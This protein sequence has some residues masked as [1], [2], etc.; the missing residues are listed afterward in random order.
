MATSNIVVKPTSITPKRYTAWH[1]SDTNIDYVS[2]TPTATKIK[3]A[4]R[5]AQWGDIATTVKL[6]E[7]MEAKDA[8]LQGVA[9]TRRM[10]ITALAWEILPNEAATDTKLADEAAVFV[11]ERLRAIPSFRTTL[12]HLQT[13]IGPNIAVAELV[14]QNMEL[15]EFV[16]VPTN[17]LRGNLLNSPIDVSVSTPENVIGVPTDEYGKWIVYSPTLRGGY[18]FKVTITSAQSWLY[19]IK[20][21]VTADWAAFSEVFGMPMRWGTVTEDADVEDIRDKVEDLLRNM[22]ADTHALL[23]AGVDIKA[24]SVGGAGSPY[25][26]LLEWIEKKTAILWLGQTLTTDVGP[27]GSFAAARVHDNVRTDILLGDIDNEANI[28]DRCV[29]EPMV[30]IKFPGRDVPLPHFNRVVI[31][32]KNLE[33][34]KLN[35]ERIRLANELGLEMDD[36]EKYQFLGITKPKQRKEEEIA[37]DDSSTATTIN[38]LTL[39][40]ERAV[41]AGD[42]SLANIIRRKIAAL[43]GEAELPPLDVP[44]LKTEDGPEPVEVGV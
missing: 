20:H 37:T 26:G 17:R 19:I 22:D 33:A 23:P 7:E 39:G 18:P 30:S 32:A 41:R 1:R 10:A 3:S 24:L 8:H 31:E 9:N 11:E 29:I 34:D 4:V 16:D 14:W 13:A 35:M 27:V 38:E 43:L 25:S 2:D 5:A 28:I 36:E 44:A 6:A 42:A 21:Y 40:L 12:K 15:D